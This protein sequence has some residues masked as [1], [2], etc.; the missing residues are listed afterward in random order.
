MSPELQ[1]MLYKPNLSL[2]PDAKVVNNRY[3]WGLE[4]QDGWF[5]ILNIA[6][7]LVSARCDIGDCEQVAVTEVKEKFGGLRIYYRGDMI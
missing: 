5:D 3:F 1:D 7:S 2:F 6:L 4:C